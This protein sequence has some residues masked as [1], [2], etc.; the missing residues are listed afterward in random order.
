[1]L[2]VVG[3][4]AAKKL[5]FLVYLPLALTAAWAQSPPQVNLVAKLRDF[6]EFNLI[7]TGLPTHPDFETVASCA[8]TGYVLAALA[9]DRAADGAFPMDN[10]SP[11][12][13][14]KFNRTSDGT[15]CFANPSRFEDWYNDRDA[16][17]NRAFLMDLTFNRNPATGLYEYINPDFFPL[18]STGPFRKIRPTDPNP[19]GHL[20][21]GFAAGVDLSKHN[22]GFTMEFHATFTYVPDS[23]QTF[24]FSGDDDVWVFINGKRVIDLGGRHGSQTQS[25]NL[26]QSAAGL[27]LV[28]YENYIL[29]FF[30]A[31]RHTSASNC[32]ITTSLV[33]DK[34]LPKPH[35]TPGTFFSGQV[36][37]TIS[38]PVPGSKI[39]YTLDGTVP[40]S[41]TCHPVDGP[42]TVLLNDTKT[43]KA[44]AIH[45]G[46]KT[47]EVASETFT[48]MDALPAPVASPPGTNFEGTQSVTLSVPGVPDAVIRYTTDGREPTAASPIYYQPLVFDQTTTLKAK[49]FKA[50]SLPSPVMTEV[51]IALVQN[52]VTL[53]AK[54]PNTKPAQ[55]PPFYPA[56]LAANPFAAIDTTRGGAATC[57]DCAP[58]TAPFFLD[59]AGVPLPEW[60]VKTKYGFLYTFQIYDNLGAFVAKT[61][62]QITDA[63][64]RNLPEDAQGFKTLSFRWFPLSS[65]HREIATGAYILKATI[66]SQTTQAGQILKSAE[67]SKLLTFGFLRP[68]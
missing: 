19:Y 36:T 38:T 10:R 17:I 64:I 62:G 20:Q 39:C 58:G 27:G 66:V 68:N 12:F 24:T 16:E 43:V 28:G 18:D 54:E 9:A 30:F 67:T 32:R 42:V 21:T 22:Y 15:P 29:D 31:E 23:N 47:S 4:C 59:E 60:S 7:T 56:E 50:Q 6:R 51:Y 44:I 13:S 49:A 40:D 45:E 25:V 34:I 65:K 33:F 41:A 1:M 52:V 48:R 26:D 55:I 37:V 57:L 35:V 63:M 14:G 2:S 46:W 53:T 8:D 5:A 11:V 61:K 3:R